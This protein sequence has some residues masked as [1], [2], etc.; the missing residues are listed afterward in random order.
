MH[1]FREAQNGSSDVSA[2][3]EPLESGSF[4]RNVKIGAASDATKSL[5]VDAV[6]MSLP[7]RYERLLRDV[8]DEDETDNS[9]IDAASKG[10]IIEAPS[11]K[12]NSNTNIIAVKS[13]KSSEGVEV[14]PTGDADASD[15]DDA[16]IKHEA[17]FLAKMSPRTRKGFF[18][19]KIK[20]I[21]KKAADMKSKI[22]PQD[23]ATTEAEQIEV[24]YDKNYLLP[25]NEARVPDFMETLHVVDTK[26][27]SEVT[28]R[29]SKSHSEDSKLASERA[30]FI[31]TIAENQ[32]QTNFEESN[33]PPKDSDDARVDVEDTTRRGRTMER[34]P[35]IGESPHRTLQSTKKAMR[36]MAQNF[37][38]SLT[39]NNKGRRRSISPSKKSPRVGEAISF[40]AV[41]N[42]LRRSLTPR[43]R[44]RDFSS[45]RTYQSQTDRA[46]SP[47]KKWRVRSF[48]LPRLPRL[49]S[50]DAKEKPQKQIVEDSREIF[51][52]LQSPAAFL[53]LQ[54]QDGAHHAYNDDGDA[55][56]QAVGYENPWH[57]G[58]G[59]YTDSCP[60]KAGDFGDPDI[61]LTDSIKRG[62][63]EPAEGDDAYYRSYEQQWK[64]EQLAQA[65]AMT[66]AERKK[67]PQVD[68]NTPVADANMTAALNRHRQA[69]REAKAVTFGGGTQL[70]ALSVGE[71]HGSSTKK[72]KTSL[73]KF[74]SGIK[75]ILK[76]SPRKGSTTKD[77][78]KQ[79]RDST[80]PDPP[81]SHYQK[82][83]GFEESYDEDSM[84]DTLSEDDGFLVQHQ[85]MAQSTAP[86]WR[87][88]PR[89]NRKQKNQK[90]APMAPFVDP[91]GM[92]LGRR[93]QFHPPRR[94][95]QQSKLQ[96][97]LGKKHDQA[98]ARRRIQ[99]PSGSTTNSV[100]D[101]YQHHRH[102]PRQ[103]HQ[104]DDQNSHLL[105]LSSEY[106]DYSDTMGYS[107]QNARVL[108]T[109]KMLH[110]VR[111]KDS[112]KN[113]KKRNQMNDDFVL[114]DEYCHY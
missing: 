106:S 59:S 46:L 108:D 20:Q 97:V 31:N 6:E 79:E 112:S 70:G 15:Y 14:A 73:R 94:P 111:R 5:E 35:P 64:R 114:F 28:S 107:I 60:K 85:I 110:A 91:A 56:T 45:Q 58:Y 62:M 2:P 9:L 25:D 65:L 29:S 19:R 39:P 103:H 69:R 50:S 22:A 87:T 27:R 49:K 90:Q 76:K 83:F 17:A 3:V 101:S 38:R 66:I 67:K 26:N 43:G 57:A 84:D 78:S 102:H 32:L 52:P 8:E 80:Y 95:E 92:R 1:G 63:E 98:N 86:L 36:S 16:I 53:S 105:N 99:A 18:A 51:A 44:R 61:D 54:V 13:E 48:S 11:H 104:E 109:L 37:R 47:K 77:A 81:G 100:I 89:K 96:R 10:T 23:E 74:A 75:G 71:T 42:R 7:E 21:Q 24:P 34:S 12:S 72:S 88:F 41:S 40:N 82:H 33:K 30:T 55:G 93:S 4:L 68:D 113:K